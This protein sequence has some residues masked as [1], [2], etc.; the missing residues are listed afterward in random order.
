MGGERV[1]VSFFVTNDGGISQLTATPR[2][3]AGKC[4][5]QQVQG[6]K[7]RVRGAETHVKIIVE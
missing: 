3:A 6:T 1:T 4:A 7:F 2:N 5:K